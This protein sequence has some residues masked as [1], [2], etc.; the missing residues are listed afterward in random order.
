MKHFDHRVA[1][2]A[3]YCVLGLARSLS[4]VKNVRHRNAVSQKWERRN[5]ERRTLTGIPA[6]IKQKRS[7]AA[8]NAPAPRILRA[9]LGEIAHN[10]SSNHAPIVAADFNHA[11]GAGMFA[12]V[13]WLEADDIICAG[14]FLD[15]AGYSAHLHGNFSVLKE[16]TVFGEG[17]SSI[18]SRACE[19]VTITGFSY[20]PVKCCPI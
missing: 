4:G 14:W 13:P 20:G 3:K 5:G 11:D 8:G 6:A 9:Q 19:P 1:A 7:A 10:A 12:I 18:S 15:A 16:Y 2:E 17:K